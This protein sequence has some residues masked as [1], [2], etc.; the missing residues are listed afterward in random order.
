MPDNNLEKGLI[1]RRICHLAFAFVIIYY[2][3]PRT[4]VGIPRYMFVIIILVIVPWSIEII[5][6]YKNTSFLGLHDH[7]RNHIASYAWFTFGAA[8][9]LLFFPQ[10]IAAPCIVATALGDP[11]MGLT[12]PYRRR[13]IFLIAFLI[14]FIVFIIFKYQPILA[15]FAAAVAIIAESF[16]FKIRIRL[17]PNLFWSRTKKRFSDYKHFFNFLF[18]TDDDFIMQIIP[19]VVLLIVFLV[20]PELMPPEIFKPLPQLAPFA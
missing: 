3:L 8:I 2:L 7:E 9:L 11:V 18:R 14:C 12:K 20:L 1:V 5:R 6:L 15:L 17:R 4:I 16:E 19:A 10:Q 13:Y